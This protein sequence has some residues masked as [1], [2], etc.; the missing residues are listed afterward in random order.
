MSGALFDLEDFAETRTEWIP[1]GTWDRCG[2]CGVKCSMN[3]GG[4]D[5]GAV[6][7]QCAQVDGCRIRP[8]D[9]VVER[10]P[11]QYGIQVEQVAHCAHCG[12]WINAERRNDDGDWVPLTP[13]EVID[14]CAEHAR[15]RH[16]SRWGMSHDISEHDVLVAAQAKRRAS[17]LRKAEA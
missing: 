10:R 4:T 2:L 12:W 11:G 6:C 8:H 5:T 1:L 15:A 14:L 16:T 13:E 9:P 7:D 3:Q 17:F